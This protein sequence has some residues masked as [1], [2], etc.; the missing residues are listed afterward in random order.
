MSFYA[1]HYAYSS[2]SA[3]LD[4]LR[5]KHREFLRS[6]ADSGSLRASGP[7]VGREPAAL[8]LFRAESAQAVRDLLAGD[9]FQGAGLV[10]RTEVSEWNP[11][12]GVFADEV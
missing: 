3:A 12:I 10:E 5:P 2:D 11:V 6:L 9:P 1:V 8:L 4:E 7:Y